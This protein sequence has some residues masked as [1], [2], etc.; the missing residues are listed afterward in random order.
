MFHL[1]ADAVAQAAPAAKTAAE[2]G[3][4]QGGLMSFLPI[5]L[6]MVVFMFFM[7][8]SQKKQ[9]QKRQEMLDRIVKGTKV[10]L[11]SGICG[12]IDEVR[13]NEFVVEIA[14]NVKIRV[15]KQ[16]VAE[17]DIPEEA[18]DDKAEEKK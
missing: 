12:V 6:I 5:I 1:V 13:D 4:G 11:A 7:S 10:T 9:Q 3:K 16:G 2:A 18:K 8:R 14:Q 17:I 15:V